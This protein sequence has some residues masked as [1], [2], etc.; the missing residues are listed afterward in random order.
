MTTAELAEAIGQTSARAAA[1][2]AHFPEL[3]ALG[4]ELARRTFAVHAQGTGQTGNL[5][6]AGSDSNGWPAVCQAGE[7]IGRVVP[8]EA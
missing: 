4:D 6:E 5:S 3:L 7:R 1:Y 2:A 8:V